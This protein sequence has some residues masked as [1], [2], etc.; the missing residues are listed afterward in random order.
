[1]G[2]SMLYEKFELRD[3]K[4]ITMRHL[5]KALGDQQEK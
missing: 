1:M 4:T 3:D 2:F 5:L